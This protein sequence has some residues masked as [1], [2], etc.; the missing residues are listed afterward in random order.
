MLKI[1]PTN[2]F[3]KDLKRYSHKQSVLAEL[4]RVINILAHK[5]PLPAK[6]HD[7]P[8]SGC[9]KGYRD[10]HIK[11]DILLIYD[12]NNEESIL[13]LVRIGSHSELFG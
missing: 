11:P 2:S 7:H 12:I 8:L 3:K 9:F 1:N 6:Y 13:Q 10:C 4:D 5:K